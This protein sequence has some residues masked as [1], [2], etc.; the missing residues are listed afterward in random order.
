MS[1]SADEE[2]EGAKGAFEEGKGG[3]F[4]FFLRKYPGE[5][6]DDRRRAKQ[7]REH[8]VERKGDERE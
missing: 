1:E 2:E 6:N 5:F 7:Q 3:A 4:D 8:D